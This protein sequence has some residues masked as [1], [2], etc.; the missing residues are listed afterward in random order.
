MAFKSEERELDI[1]D[2]GKGKKE[3]SGKLEYEL[4]WEFIEGMAKRMAKNKGKYPPYNWHKPIDVSKL[5][6]SLSRHFVEVMK[7]NFSDDQEMGHL[8]ALAVNAMMIAYQLNGKGKELQ[9]NFSS[10]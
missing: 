9:L 1:L 5:Q 6:Q 7:G 10:I 8:Y 3:S 4:D 2:M